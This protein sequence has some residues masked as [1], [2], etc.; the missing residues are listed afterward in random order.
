MINDE[1]GLAG[2]AN[3]ANSLPSVAL[4]TLIDGRFRCSGTLISP[5]TLLTARH[6]PTRAGDAVF[7]GGDPGA[8]LL[9]T[10][11][12]EVSNPA[13]PIQSG[14]L[15]G[16]D[17]EILTLATAVPNSVAQ[18]LRLT[19]LTDDLVGREAILAGF[20]ASGIGSEGHGG[21]NDG[22]RRA[23]T[24]II[25]SYGRPAGGFVGANIFSTD[26]DNGTTLANTIEDSD[27]EPLPF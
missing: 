19:D 18:P 8:P 15:S 26:F 14:I 3:F 17:V 6:C 20:G 25:D 1:I 9:T 12:S 13:P 5:T 24:N 22:L 7:F 23:G 16:G 2:A 11:V 4:V 10:S 21:S 27:P